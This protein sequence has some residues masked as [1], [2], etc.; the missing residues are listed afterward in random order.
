MLIFPLVEWY[1][2]CPYI[3]RGLVVRVLRLHSPWPSGTSVAPTFPV[4]DWY[5]C[6]PYIPRGRVV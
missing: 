5:E 6:C 3:P 2:C 4:A 1:E